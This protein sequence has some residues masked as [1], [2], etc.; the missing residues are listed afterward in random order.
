MTAKK[1]QAG[2]KPARTRRSSAKQHT[3]A[4]RRSAARDG[5]PA[6]AKRRGGRARQ[7]ADAYNRSLIEA[8]LD[9][10][11]TITPDGKIGDVNPATEAATGYSRAELIGKDFSD[12]F[13]DGEKARAGYRRAFEQ[14]EVHNYELEIRHREGGVTPVLYNASVFTDEKGTVKGVL[15]AARDIT[16]LRQAESRARDNTR[17]VEMMADISHL[18]AEAGPQ[19]RSVLPGIAERITRLLGD[20]CLIHLPG[21]HGRLQEA[22]RHSAADG[23]SE[24]ARPSG[25]PDGLIEKAFRTRRP[26]LR[27]GETEDDAAPPPRLLIVPLLFQN[28]ALGTVLVVRNTLRRPYRTADVSLLQ[29]IADRMALAI[30]NSTLYSD[31]KKALADEQKTRRQLVQSEKLAAMGRVLGSVAHELNN[32]L[33]TIKNCLYLVKQEAPADPSIQEYID[34]ASSETRRLVHL[35]AQLRDLYRPRSG[36]AMQRHDLGAILR[37]VRALEAPQLQKNGVEWKD[38]DGPRSVT[39]RCD[40][41]RIQQVFIN[42]VTNAV[43]AMQPGGGVLTAGLTLSEDSSRAGAVFHDTGPGVDPEMK[44][45][46]G[47]P[48]I[49][50]KTGGLGLGLSICYE[51]AQ[52]HGGSI[53]AENPPGG[54][55][56][57]TFWL[58]LEAD[59]PEG[60]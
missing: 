4:P 2:G 9:P 21:A 58:P 41:E 5:R 54:G 17:R 13:T 23:R 55:A 30:A 52:Q 40:R 8:S 16:L 15:A 44:R 51:I 14:G 38:R 25:I 10:L 28:R 32:P 42:L 20:E 34:M 7:L 1:K 60:Q 29:T 35:V 50:T 59:G 24:R 48:F 57:F 49:T 33:Q 56:V 19:Y 53:S 22:A 37:D 12:C 43:E 36:K 47:D 26:L 46:L 39:V 27:P 6:G 3:S 45:H 31:L 18:L 11:M